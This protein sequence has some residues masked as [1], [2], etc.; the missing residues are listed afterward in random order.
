MKLKLTHKN[1]F[2]IASTS[3]Q[4][5]RLSILSTNV[6]LFFISLLFIWF[7][8]ISVFRIFLNKIYII[9]KY[10]PIWW[11]DISIFKWENIQ[12]MEHFQLMILFFIYQV[13]VNPI[14]IK[15]LVKIHLFLMWSQGRIQRTLHHTF[16]DWLQSQK[17][18][19]VLFFNYHIKWFY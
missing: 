17:L 7:Y 15:M 13:S 11:W 18:L 9:C 6:F 16:Y 5:I 1:Q 10:I 3:Y 8:F 14:P 12:Q 2:K 19:L 4:V